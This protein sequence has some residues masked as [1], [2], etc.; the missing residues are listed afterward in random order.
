MKIRLQQVGVKSQENKFGFAK[1]REN[2]P[3]DKL[4]QVIFEFYGQ[5]L[6]IVREREKAK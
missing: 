2:S 6:D 1:F 4:E 3:E 5:K